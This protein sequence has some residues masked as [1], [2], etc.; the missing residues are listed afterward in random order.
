MGQNAGR[1]AWFY[2][3]G[4]RRFRATHAGLPV[5]TPGGLEPPTFSLE[6]CC[7]IQL[8]Y[9]AEGYSD[10]GLRHHHKEYQRSPDGAKR[11]PGQLAQIT[12][13][14]TPFHPGYGEAW[15]R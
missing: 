3:A 2:E 10:I 7:S 4:I 12:R 6:G 1:P 11:N 14:S 8:S 15:P 13:R 9:G 5:A